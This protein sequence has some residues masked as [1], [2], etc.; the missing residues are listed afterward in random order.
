[1]EIGSWTQEECKIVAN[2]A[3]NY[4]IVAEDEELPF[5]PSSSEAFADALARQQPP[6]KE[7]RPVKSQALAPKHIEEGAPRPLTMIGFYILASITALLGFWALW[8]IIV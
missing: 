5:S 3:S 8:S 6:K 7:T 1:M 4:L 2:G